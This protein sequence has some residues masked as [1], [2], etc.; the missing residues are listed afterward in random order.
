[1]TRFS[2]KCAHKIHNHQKGIF[3]T[4]GNTIQAILESFQESQ[5]NEYFGDKLTTKPNENLR[6]VSLN[7]N[8]IDLGKGEHSLLQLCLNLQD[9]GIDLLC[10]TE[11]NV[12]WQRHN[13]VQIFSL[14]LKKAWPKQNISLCTLD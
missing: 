11:T 9:K 2:F 4:N 1:M 7:I 3:T 12:N 8:G 10:L 14:T 13:L 6:I 5:R